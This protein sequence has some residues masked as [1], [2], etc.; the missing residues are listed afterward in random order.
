[1]SDIAVN[2]MTLE[3]NHITITSLYDCSINMNIN[4]L[5]SSLFKIRLSNDMWTKVQEMLNTQY[6]VRIDIGTLATGR[7]TEL[8]YDKFTDR[9]GNLYTYGDL[10]IKYT[11][12]TSRQSLGNSMERTDMLLHPPKV[13]TCMKEAD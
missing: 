13:I 5:G 4:G 8:Q 12:T 2:N 3:Q 11:V 10:T 7:V 9:Q 6:S 1:M